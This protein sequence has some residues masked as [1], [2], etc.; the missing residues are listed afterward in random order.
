PPRR[1]SIHSRRAVHPARRGGAG[2]AIRG[3]AGHVHVALAGG[4]GARLPGSDRTILGGRLERARRRRAAQP[5]G[6]PHPDRGGASQRR[7]RRRGALAIEW[8]EGAPALVDL[9]EHTSQARRLYK[10]GKRDAALRALSAA[11]HNVHVDEDTWCTAL[12]LL[13]AL[14]VEA[15]LPDEAL[16]LA[17]YLDD[18]EL[19]QS[20]LSR[21]GPGDRARTW[22]GQA[23]LGPPGDKQRLYQRAAAEFETAGLLVH[24]AVANERAGNVGAARALWSRL[25]ERLESETNQNQSYAVGLAR[26]NVART[27]LAQQE[28][29][30]AREAT[31][32]A[33]HRLEEAADRFESIAQRERAFDCYHVLVAIGELTGS[34]EHVLEGSVN[35]IRILRQDNLQ[36]HALSLYEHTIELARAA[37]ESAA[38][39]TL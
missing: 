22:S 32:A 6:A 23:A 24:A 18:S 12:H 36:H 17:W 9:G 38:A 11:L 13:H 29:A 20:V 37:S 33:V 34:F 10:R 8:D 2:Q 26:F 31:V 25:A 7:H 19:I 27:C 21:V 3:A 15:E 14:F 1:A 30:A 5:R 4:A 16:T 39:A 35:A 28:S